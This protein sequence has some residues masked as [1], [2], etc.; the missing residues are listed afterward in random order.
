MS[1][2]CRSA[3][4]RGSSL[5]AVPPACSVPPPLVT[6]LHLGLEGSLC[7]CKRMNIGAH[8]AGE[9]YFINRLTAAHE[10]TVGV[11]VCMQERGLLL[12][13]FP[14]CEVE[15]FKVLEPYEHHIREKGGV[16]FEDIFSVE[17]PPVEPVREGGE[18]E[19]I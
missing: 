17:T 19:Y 14:F 3:E 15:A 10:A 2:A 11:A 6:F 12:E 4:R 8:H 16:D 18:E 7:A 5:L 13:D 9:V 1:D